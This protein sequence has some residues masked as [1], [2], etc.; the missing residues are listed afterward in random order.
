MLASYRLWPLN[1]DVSFDTV[2]L[3]L[4]RQVNQVERSV[5]LAAEIDVSVFG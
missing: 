5:H 2:S 3:M 4:V 1:S